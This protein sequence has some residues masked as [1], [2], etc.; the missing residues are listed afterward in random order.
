MEIY[1]CF[2]DVLAILCCYSIFVM[3]I[4]IFSSILAL[5]PDPPRLILDNS[6][7]KRNPHMNIMRVIHIAI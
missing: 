4:I 6:G 3:K 7:G 5:I 1:N 2:F